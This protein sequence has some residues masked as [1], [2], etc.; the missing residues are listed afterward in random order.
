MSFAPT[1]RPG[2]GW[3]AALAVTAI[4]LAL[5]AAFAQSGAA[6]TAEEAA[7]LTPILPLPPGGSDELQASI[8]SR[9]ALAIAA[10]RVQLQSAATVAT[11]EQRVA[12]SWPWSCARADSTVANRF[13]ASSAR[14]RVPMSF[15]FRPRAS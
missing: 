7:D 12:F 11:A 5:F 10:E 8:A 2:V 3:A 14:V 13:A 4:P 15:V 6:P 1:R 9:L